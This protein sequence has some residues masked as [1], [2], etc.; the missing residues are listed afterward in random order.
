MHFSQAHTEHS[1]EQTRR[2]DTNQVVINFKRLKPHKMLLNTSINNRVT[3][4][5][6]DIENHSFLHIALW[7]N[8]LLN[9]INTT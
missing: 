2:W 4:N 6:I 9:H 7:L 5:G 8:E 1:P 3:R